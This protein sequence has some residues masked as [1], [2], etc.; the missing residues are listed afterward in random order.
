[1]AEQRVA[2][3]FGLSGIVHH[4]DP[5][6]EHVRSEPIFEFAGD[7]RSVASWIRDRLS[8]HLQVVAQHLAEQLRGGGGFEQYWTIVGLAHWSLRE[9]PDMLGQLGRFYAAAH[10][11][12]EGHP[13]S[14]AWIT[15]A[16]RTSVPS[17]ARPYAD[18]RI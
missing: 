11:R 17:G 16:S 14:K 4:V 18:T 3:E 2:V 6:G 15:S 9:R 8:S 13:R 1:M 7:V 12:R 10:P 5:V